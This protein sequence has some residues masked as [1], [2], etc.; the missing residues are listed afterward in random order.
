[1]RLLYFGK[2]RQPPLEEENHYRYLWGKGEYS[3][4]PMKKNRGLLRFKKETWDTCLKRKK[5]K[6]KLLDPG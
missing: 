5:R 4:V 3:Y 6:E 2:G 1:M